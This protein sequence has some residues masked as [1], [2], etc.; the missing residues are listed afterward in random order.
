MNSQKLSSRAWSRSVVSSALP[1]TL[2]ALCAFAVFV[3]VLGWALTPA[4]AHC[5]G[6]HSGN[7]PHCDVGPPNDNPEGATL[8]FG[9]RL[10]SEARDPL[11]EGGMDYLTPIQD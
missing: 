3:L 10:L 4:Q 8:N 11:M 9:R 7:H 6:R 1:R 5:D 2:T